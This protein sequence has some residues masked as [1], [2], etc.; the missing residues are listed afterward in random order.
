MSVPVQK[1]HI[2]TVEP[3]VML[4]HMARRAGGIKAVNQLT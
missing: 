1:A 4:G 3:V 2:L